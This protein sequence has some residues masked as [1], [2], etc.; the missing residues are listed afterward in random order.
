M[1]ICAS[2]YLKPGVFGGK[3]YTFFLEIET[4]YSRIVMDGYSVLLMCYMCHMSVQ[5]ASVRNFKSFSEYET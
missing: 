1:R 4:R 3:G 2:I 5:C